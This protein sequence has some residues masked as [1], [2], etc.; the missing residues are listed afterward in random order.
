MLKFWTLIYRHLQVTVRS[1]ALTTITSRQCSAIS[2]RPFRNKRTLGPQS[3][4][5]QTHLCLNQLH[6]GLHPTI[7]VFSRI[8]GVRLRA[9]QASS[10]WGAILHEN[11]VQK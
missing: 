9:G 1:G 7:R 11:T 2:G 5:T 6:Y 4:A 8:W 10:V 3:A